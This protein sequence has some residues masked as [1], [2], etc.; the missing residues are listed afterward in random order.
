[1]PKSAYGLKG[2][3]NWL[4][5]DELVLT[6]RPARIR[7]LPV[8]GSLST[9]ITVQTLTEDFTNGANTEPKRLNMHAE[10]S[11]TFRTTVGN[12]SPEKTWT[13]GK[14]T[15]I[16][17]R[18]IADSITRGQSPGNIPEKEACTLTASSETYDSMVLKRRS[19]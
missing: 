19:L 1:M 14:A 5:E 16:P 6:C 4:P 10:P 18:A 17:V 11:P 2:F 7:Q 12:I 13:A 3:Q 15:H 9:S 8:M